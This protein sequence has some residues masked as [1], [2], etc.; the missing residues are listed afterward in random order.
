MS[1]TTLLGS[2]YEEKGDY[3]N[4]EKYLKIAA[5]AGDV[6]A[7]YKIVDLYEKNKKFSQ[8]DKY[9]KLIEESK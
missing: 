8:R 5:D 9:L 6:N 1:G 2:L 3:K 7:M 4:A